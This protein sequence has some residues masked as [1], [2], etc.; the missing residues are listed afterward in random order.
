MRKVDGWHL[1]FAIGA[2][3]GCIYF[4]IADHA[5]MAAWMGSFWKVHGVAI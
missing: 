1:A 4:V 3:L 5:L 2:F